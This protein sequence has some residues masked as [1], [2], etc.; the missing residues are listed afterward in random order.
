MPSD[1]LYYRFECKLFSKLAK[2]VKV[3]VV[4]AE[5]DLQI[6]FQVPQHVLNY[7]ELDDEKAY[8]FMIAAAIKCK[9]PKINLSVVQF[10]ENDN[11]VLDTE[12]DKKKNKKDTK[13]SKIPSK[14]DISAPNI[15]IN[16]KIGLLRTKYTCHADDGSDYCWV[17]GEEKQHIALGHAHFNLWAAAWGDANA[18]TPPNH[19]IFSGKGN[20]GCAPPLILQKRITANAVN[21]PVS[22]APTINVSFDGLADLLR[23]APAPTAAAA[24]PH[25]ANEPNMLIPPNTQPGE[26]ISISMFCIQYNLDDCILEKLTANRYKNASAFRLFRLMDLEKNG[27]F[28][29]PHC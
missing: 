21:Q 27:V 7:V 19:A 9:D 14:N 11:K 12:D 3:A 1:T 5:D 24:P 15:E 2:L 26:P 20:S 16:A 6:E 28:A 13:K 29:G 8:K 10:Q 25:H 17:S 18:D 4:S 23:P 22:T